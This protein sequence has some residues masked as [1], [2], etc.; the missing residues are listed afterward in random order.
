MWPGARALG[1]RSFSDS[2]LDRSATARLHR[3]VEF[4][5]D[6]AA[7]V[8]P[9]RLSAG[10]AEVP[11]SQRRLSLDSRSKDYAMVSLFGVL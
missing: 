2:F 4:L 8:P 10:K 9:S 3:F 7:L 5:N 1:F 11:R 6:P